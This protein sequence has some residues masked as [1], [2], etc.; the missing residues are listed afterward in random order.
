MVDLGGA[1]NTREGDD[2][3]WVR[4]AAARAKGELCAKQRDADSDIRRHMTTAYAARDMLEILKRL[5]DQSV[6]SLSA[7][8]K[9]RK[10]PK[11]KFLGISYGT[12]V[13]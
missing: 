7:P 12:M 8:S 4:I 13:G 5:A 9:E 2:A 6:D 11:L 1:M 10:I 3:L